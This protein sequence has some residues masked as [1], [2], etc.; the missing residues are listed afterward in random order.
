M[1]VRGEAE[2]EAAKAVGDK[3]LA[4]T[5]WTN[6]PEEPPY[7]RPRED[8]APPESPAAQASDAEGSV[9]SDPRSQRAFE[10]LKAQEDKEKE[11]ETRR[12]ERIARTEQEKV[13][14]KAVAE[15]K[16]LAE[17]NDPVAKSQKWLLGA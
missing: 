10:L 15:A 1:L 17:Q 3:L 6:A 13:D 7:K 12:L 16:K 14:R 5:G 11:K 8:H 2:P 9:P 4:G